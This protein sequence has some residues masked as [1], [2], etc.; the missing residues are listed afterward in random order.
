MKPEGPELKGYT[1]YGS[2]YDPNC[3]RLVELLEAVEIEHTL[4]DLKKWPPTDEQII[5]WGE[6]QGEE[7]AINGRST[8]FKKIERV[9]KKWTKQEQMNWIRLNP[10]V[11]ERPIIED[12]EGVVLS[13]GG[14]P[15]RVAKNV[16]LIE[17]D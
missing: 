5:K 14:R 3:T 12:P 16:F 2:D 6:F 9:F 11:L 4:V 10:H 8:P 15:E 1:I 7:Y 13:M 17:I